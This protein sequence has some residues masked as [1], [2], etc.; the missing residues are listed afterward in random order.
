MRLNADV[1]E[2]PAAID[3]GRQQ[4]LLALVDDANVACGG[5]AGD[6]DTMAR[7]VA[8]CRALGV[9]VGAHPSTPDRAGFG[10]API[11]GSPRDVEDAVR[12]QLLA[13]RAV[14][15]EAGVALAHVKPHGALYHAAGD[16]EEWALLLL[17]AVR[18]AGLDAPLVLIA[19]A[20]TAQALRA[21]GVRVLA[22]GFAD[23]AYDEQGRLVPRGHPGA[24]VSDAALAAAQVRRLALHGDVDT[25]CVHGDTPGALAVARAVRDALGP[26]G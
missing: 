10:R 16:H 17:R 7:T 22:E 3:D 25:V 8:Q 19:G 21:Q 26:R 23:R 4:D 12:A 15:E 13:L 24:L 5:H 1:G 9:A 6:L 14:C 18:S 11:A 20:R 2:H